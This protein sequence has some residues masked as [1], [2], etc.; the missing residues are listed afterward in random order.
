MRRSRFQSTRPARGETFHRR[1]PSFQKEF[2]ST[3]PARGETMRQITHYVF[4]VYFNPLAP[5][6]A[7][8]RL[9][10]RG[11]QHLEISIHSPRKGRDIDQPPKSDAG[12]HF[13]PLAPQGARLRCFGRLTAS[14]GISIHS[15]RKGRD[16]HRA[17]PSPPLLYFNPLAPQGARQQTIT[18]TVCKNHSYCLT[19][20]LIYPPKGTLGNIKGCADGRNGMDRVRTY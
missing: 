14:M 1:C 12:T 8:L 13:N 6:G 17:M 18:K 3:R 4:A 16:L 2:Q 15:P 10:E 7:R 9:Q 20:T 5:Q 11:L 19:Y